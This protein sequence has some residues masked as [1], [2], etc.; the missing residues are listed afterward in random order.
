MID[1]FP[2]RAVALTL[3]GWQIHWYGLLYL[4]AFLIAWWLLPRLQKVRSLSISPDEW[5]RVL[6]WAVLG[7][8][9]GGR[10]GYV[11]FYAPFYYFSH[12]SEIIAVWHGGMASHG[13][14]LGVVLA[15]LWALRHR[16]R[17]EI[18]AI[19]DVIAIPAAIGLAL[20]RIGNFINLEV[21]GTVTTLPWGM[22]IPGVEGLRHPT[23]LYAV[24]KDLLI[25]SVCF[26]HLR[27]ASSRPGRTFALFLML[28]GVLRFLIEFLREQP[29][30]VWEF[31]FLTLTPGQLLTIPLFVV[32]AVM[33]W[34]T[35]NEGQRT[36]D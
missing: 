15:L 12:I 23:Q 14:F 3:F 10:L 25:A 21:Y 27:S 26:L 28:Y 1:F 16:S 22:A 20:G 8:I 4:A 34:G 30:G 31:G 9:V 32:G 33:W 7:V 24:F 36:K 11:F 13:G 18:L 35:G 5:S 29:Y 2:S 19:A 17:A 6:S